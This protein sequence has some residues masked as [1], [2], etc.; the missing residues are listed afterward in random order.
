MTTHTDF[1]IEKLTNTYVTGI[2]QYIR[3]NEDV[4]ESF[5][6]RITA[7]LNRY[8]GV[9]DEVKVEYIVLVN[10]VRKR[11]MQYASLIESGRTSSRYK[12]DQQTVISQ[13][14]ED[15]S[16]VESDSKMLKRLLSFSKE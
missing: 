12:Q 6:N 14:I 10:N 3:D 11:A 4:P 15:V 1:T 13:L 9:P 7:I 5:G 16:K 8:A 2:L